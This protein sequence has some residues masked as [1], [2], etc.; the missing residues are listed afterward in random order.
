MIWN[1]LP[2]VTYVE[3]TQL[4]IG[5]FDSLAH[6]NIGKKAVILIYEALGMNPGFYT[7]VGCSNANRVVSSGHIKL[8]V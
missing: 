2:K 4:Q 7:T 1:R 6:F 8:I 3:L 5:V